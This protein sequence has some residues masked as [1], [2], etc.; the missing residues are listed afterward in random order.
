[1]S[2][3]PHESEQWARLAPYLDRA[4]DVPATERE[5]WLVGLAGEHP[6]IAASLRQLLAEYEDIQR[7]GFLDTSPVDTLRN[8][9]RKQ[10]M[11]SNDQ[12][13]PPLFNQNVAAGEQLAAYRLIREI[14]RGGMSSVWLAQRS[15]GQLQR[16]VALKLPF[17]GPRQA[18]LAERFRRERDILATLT[19][20]NIARLYDAGVTAEGQPYLAM[21]YVEGRALTSYCDCAQLPIRE[22]LGLFLQV[23]AAVEF[24]HSQLVLHRDLK[25]SNILVTPQGRVVLLDFGIAK[26]LSDEMPLATTITQFAGGGPLTPDYASPEQIAAQ[27]VGTASDIY[28]LGVVLHELLVGGRTFDRQRVSRRQLEEAI[29]TQDPQRPSQLTASDDIATARRTTPRKLA[30]V[31]KGDLDTIVLKTLKKSPVERYLSV[32]ALSQDIANYLANLPVSARPD[33]AWYRSRRFIARHKFHVSAA[34]AAVLALAIG[35]GTAVWQW[36][37]AAK[38]RERAVARLADSEATLEFT[39]AVL[40]DGI[41][42]DESITIDALRARSEQIVEQLGVSDARTRV[43]AADFVADWYLMTDQFDRADKLLTR[44]IDSLPADEHIAGKS[45]LACRRANAWAQLGRVEEAIAVVTR[46][47]ARHSSDD[48]EISPCLHIRAQMAINLND[49]QNGLQYAL[50][51]LR[52]FDNTGQRSLRTRASLLADIG[53]AYSV[54]G[55]PDRAQDYYQQA[56]ALY[57]RVGHGDSLD[58][59]TLLA[60]WG[61]IMFAAGNPLQALD[62]LERSLAINRRRMVTG[63]H[64]QYSYANLGGVLRALARYR[65]ADTAYDMS[66]STGARATPQ[67]EVYALVGKARVAALEGRFEH[68]QEL[69]QNAAARMREGQVPA[70]SSGA[71]A[72]KLVQGQ[73][74]AGRGQLSQAVTAFTEVI[75]NYAKLDC[76]SGPRAQALVARAS[77]LV[78]DRQLDAAAKDAQQAL[79]FAQRAQGQLPSSGVTGQAWLM[80]ADVRQAQGRNAEA[81]QA[82]ALAVRHLVD[83]LGEQHPDTLRARQALAGG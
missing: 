55:M 6:D 30:Q 29:L 63:E 26:L 77:A 47:I 9:W 10:G 46:E 40:M 83:T 58:A 74:S 5:Q 60:N 15:D 14:G 35:L 54:K 18:E 52:H 56:F 38:D 53:A 73:V 1:M 3:A 66:L 79:T 37:M 27:P 81:N 39:R 48:A 67:A 51:A 34:A 61:V 70:G 25:P 28:S 7:R 13:G 23:L 32:G 68:A 8:A 69:L 16:E 31:L 64:A 44:T 75:D 78:T 21:E 41:R 45:T 80:L 65:E 76:C 12:A 22:R 17:Q 24:A 59:G 72:H 11:V 82:Y 71:L 2:F 43:V 57:E 42:N 36:Q 50:Q 4:L 62:L 49:A 20:P 33:S 19:H